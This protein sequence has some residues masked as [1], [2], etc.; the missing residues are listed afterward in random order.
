MRRGVVPD[1]E[2]ERIREIAKVAR[3]DHPNR[4]EVASGRVDMLTAAAYLVIAGMVA[5]WFWRMVATVVGGSR[6]LLLVSLVYGLL[7]PITVPATSIYRWWKL[8]KISEQSR[9]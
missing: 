2:R 8:R 4:A 9:L 5:V 6:A 1:V 3:E 7:W